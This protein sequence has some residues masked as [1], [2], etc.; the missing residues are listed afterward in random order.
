MFKYQI[1]KLSKGAK[2]ARAVL[3][4]DILTSDVFGL[5][6][7]LP[8][9]LLFKPF[10]EQIKIDN[11]E[12]DF[13]VPDSE[14]LAIHFWKTYIWPESLPKLNR[15][16]IEPDVVIEW[17]DT[18]LIVEAKFVSA[19]DPEELLREYLI[20][21]SEA[22]NDKAAFLLLID[23][24]LSPPEV[25]HNSK[26]DK[27]PVSEYIQ[28][29]IEALQLTEISPPEKVSPS[30]LWTNWQRFYTQVEILRN[31]V[32]YRVNGAFGSSAGKILKDLL[33][34]LKRKGLKPFESLNLKELSKLR[35]DLNSFGRMGQMVDDPVPSL[36][37]FKLNPNVLLR[38]LPFINS[39]EISSGR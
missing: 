38:Q 37:N 10:L 7:Y 3:L 14:P 19:T 32:L 24:N 18:L 39:Q 36:S 22:A 29:R 5:M 13:S 34:I 27:V 6:S 30:I 4:E 28:N 31:E 25:N 2:E 35:I 12:S 8:Y 33:A 26:P 9:G 21:W 1:H 17:P 15:A 16:S 11:P 23:G 20:G